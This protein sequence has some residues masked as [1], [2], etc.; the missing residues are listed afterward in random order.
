MSLHEGIW[1]GIEVGES[2]TFAPAT[3]ARSGG[4]F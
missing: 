4:K 3:I 1:S 2:P